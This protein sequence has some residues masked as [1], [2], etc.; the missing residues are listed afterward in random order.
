MNLGGYCRGPLCEQLQRGRSRSTLWRVGE[1]YQLKGRITHM[2]DGK[3]VRSMIDGE[4]GGNAV[5]SM[6]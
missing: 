2:Y 3:V 5:R 6:V 4:S 1:S